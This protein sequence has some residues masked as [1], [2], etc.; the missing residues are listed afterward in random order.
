M[1]ILLIGGCGYIGS[2]L[3]DKLSDEK[4]FNIDICDSEI[5]GNQNNK[6][7]KY[8]LYEELN[9][10]ELKNYDFVLWFAGHSSVQQSLKDPIGAYLN[11]SINLFNLIQKLNNKT[12]IIY[13][14]SASLYSDRNVLPILSS[15]NSLI[16]IPDNNSYDRSKF[17]FDYMVEDTFDRF[18]GLRMGTLAG[19]SSN[20]RKELVFNSMSI[21][22][23]THKKIYIQ[24]KDSWRSILFLSDLYHTIINIINKSPQSGFYNVCSYNMRMIDLA[25]K[26][27]EFYNAEIID[28]GNS[29]TYSFRMDNKKMLE[30]CGNSYE[31]SSFREQCKKF[32]R[33]YNE[34]LSSK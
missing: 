2:Y 4:S 29:I 8:N 19:F 12:K 10:D 5:R 11:N 16:K 9:E 27:G 3:F 31:I 17:A 24:N 22:A 14:S 18:Y 1:N 30:T 32:E 21:D 20:I 33:E 23:I 34:F 26:I 28:K 7:I 25:T 15:E 6:V 13:A